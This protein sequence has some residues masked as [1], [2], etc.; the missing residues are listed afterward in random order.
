MLISKLIEELK[1]CQELSGDIEVTFSEEKMN[2]Y[3]LVTD[4]WIQYHFRD[5]NQPPTVVLCNVEGVRQ[6]DLFIN[7][8]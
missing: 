5:P 4:M 1:Q 8:A 3:T 7:W 6:L 2:K